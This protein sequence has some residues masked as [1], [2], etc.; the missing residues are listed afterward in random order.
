MILQPPEYQGLAAHAA[1]RRQSSPDAN[2]AIN[3]IEEEVRRLNALVNEVLDYAKPI[4]FDYGPVDLN[5]LCR[6]AATAASAGQ[7]APGVRLFED[8]GP[9]RSSRTPNGCGWCW[10]TC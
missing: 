2:E 6:A 3:D 5:A 4:R 7:P 8:R 1:P 10:S 9:A